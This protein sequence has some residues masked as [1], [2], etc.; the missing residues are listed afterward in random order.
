VRGKRVLQVVFGGVEGKI[1]NKQFRTHVMSCCPL[2]IPSIQTVPDCRVSIITEP[3][4][5]EDFHAVE[6]TSYLYWTSAQ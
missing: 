4:S 1:S 3:S 5:L 2:R 6:L